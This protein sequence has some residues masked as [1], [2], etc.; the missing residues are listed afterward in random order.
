MSLR[1]TRLATLAAAQYDTMGYM[2]LEAMSLGC[3]LVTTAVGEF[4]NL[5]RIIE[6]VFLFARKTSVP[7][8]AA[9]K[10][11]LNDNALAARL[12]RAGVAGLPRIIRAG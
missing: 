3:P 6:M 8:L 4:R 7:W 1:T 11:L 12:G 9:C 2:I 5:L 10:E